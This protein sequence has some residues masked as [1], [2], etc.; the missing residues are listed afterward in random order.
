MLNLNN[1]SDL[2]LKDLAE[3]PNNAG[4]NTYIN[5]VDD[6]I[7]WVREPADIKA[8][9]GFFLSNTNFKWERETREVEREQYN[10]IGVENPHHA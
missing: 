4:F 10:R 6:A 5:R 3:L 9:V 7:L 8:I 2:P 1:Y